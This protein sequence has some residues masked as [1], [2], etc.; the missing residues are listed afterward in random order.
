[1]RW[2]NASTYVLVI[3]SSTVR[4]SSASF[5][6]EI[7][8]LSERYKLAPSSATDWFV[9]GCAMCYHV[10]VILYVKDLQLY[11]LKV[12]H[13]VPVA[14]IC[15]SLCSLHLLHSDITVF[16]YNQINNS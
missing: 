4:P 2:C 14:G 1:M 9:K 3:I 8:T 6:L 12:G 11:I 7:H 13:H 16:K 10:Y 15:L 5:V